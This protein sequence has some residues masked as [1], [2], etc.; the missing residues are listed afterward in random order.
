MSDKVWSKYSTGYQWT[1]NEH[2]TI[3]YQGTQRTPH[4]LRRRMPHI[5]TWCTRRI[6][7]WWLTAQ[8]TQLTLRSDHARHQ[9]SVSGCPPRS[10]A[11]HHF[12][13]LFS[14]CLFNFLILKWEEATGNSYDHSVESGTSQNLKANVTDAT[15]LSEFSHPHHDTSCAI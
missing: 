1:L 4:V 13:S 8:V 11:S 3:L 7:F 5:G 15:N 2:W 12:R 6:A 9:D 10:W 14:L